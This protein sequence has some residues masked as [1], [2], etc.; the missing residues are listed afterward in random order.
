MRRCASAIPLLVE[1]RPSIRPFPHRQR[2][3]ALRPVPAAGSLFPACIFETI[4]KPSPARSVFRSRPD[5]AFVPR[6]ARSRREPVAGSC[7]RTHPLSSNG[8]SPPGPLS[9][10]GSMRSTRFQ[11]AKPA[12]ASRPI[13][14]R[15]P[16][17]KNFGRRE[18]DQRSGSATS[19]QAR[20]PSNLLE[21]PSSCT[22]PPA[23]SI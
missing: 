12:F 10:S 1:A 7:F 19:R 20:C 13:F 21:P 11:P 18:A 5:W 22:H 2:E 17:R 15:S 9:P 6:Q 14:L 4:L 23:G 16:L 8:R 3:R